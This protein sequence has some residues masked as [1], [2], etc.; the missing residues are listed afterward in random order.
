MAAIRFSYGRFHLKKVPQDMFFARGINTSSFY[1]CLHVVRDY[2]L[3]GAGLSRPV[4][5]SC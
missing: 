2:V 5:G 4:L 1:L 3:K